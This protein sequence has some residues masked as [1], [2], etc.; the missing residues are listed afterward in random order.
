MMFVFTL[1]MKWMTC[2]LFAMSCKFMFQ[3]SRSAVL[4]DHKE[5]FLKTLN[6]D[7]GMGGFYVWLGLC[8]EKFKISIEIR[9]M[10]IIKAV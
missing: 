3:L 2:V 1:F 6:L 7:G 8:V 10:K 4:G 5:G 9:C